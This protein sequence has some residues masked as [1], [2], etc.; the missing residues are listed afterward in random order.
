MV[1]DISITNTVPK[2]TITFNNPTIVMARHLK[3]LYVKAHFN[4]ILVSKVLVDNGASVNILSFRMMKHLQKIEK[5]LVEANISIVGFSRVSVPPQGLLPITVSIGRTTI[6]TKFFVVN[7]SS[8]Y[9]ALLGRDWIHIAW[10]VPLTLYQCL[11]LE[12]TKR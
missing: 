11:I 2:T 8:H 9:N 6:I 12:R 1:Q 3:P 5:D 7:T 4:G 10:C